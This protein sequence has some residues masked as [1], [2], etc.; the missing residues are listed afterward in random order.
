M[1]I[2]FVQSSNEINKVKELLGF[3]PIF[4]PLSLESLIYCDLKKIDY[5][6]PEILI[7]KNF[8]KIASNACSDLIKNLNLNK[9][10]FEFIRNEIKSIIR[11]KFNQIA[12]LIE[13]IDSLN[14]QKKITEIILTNQYS[15][16][17]YDVITKFPGN[18]FTNIEIIFLEIFKNYKIR[19]LDI[20]EK[21]IKNDLDLNHEYKITGLRY[22]N[23]KKIFFNNS[24]YNF[25]R[26]IIFLLKKRYKI[27]F[28]NEGIPFY[29]RFIFKIFGIEIIEFQKIRNI[30][31]K[32]K[33]NSNIKFTF[34]N[35]DISR[36]LNN[37]LIKS[38]NYLFDL[39]NKFKALS[40]FFDSSKIKLVIS[41]ANRGSGG[42]IVEK[43]VSKKIKSIMISHGTIAKSFDSDD[44]VYKKIIAEGVFS[45]KADYH[46][47]QSRITLDSLDTHKLTGK[48]LTTGN[49]VFAEGKQKSNLGKK[50]NCLYAVTNK[51]F[52]AMQFLGLEMYYEFFNNLN[53]LDNF[54]KENNYNFH[55]HL[56]YGAKDCINLL[57]ERFKNLNFTSGKIEKS[58]KNATVTISYSST[59]IEDSLHFRVPVILFD[60][61]L[62]YRHCESELDP[63]KKNRSIYYI[64]KNNDLRECL[65]T[66]RLSK[67]INFEEHIFLDY[68]KENIK[69]LFSNLI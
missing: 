61:R 62:R 38:S 3:K 60:P 12:L 9:F 5:L 39:E 19:V 45:G 65:E 68:S 43:A 44:E 2:C 46:A 40:N 11:F 1:K 27:S 28:F 26:L 23:K 30:K 6:N 64:N 57:K 22:K 13:I 14:K 7:E 58:L 69:R 24:G 17:E 63:R 49:L 34:K 67:N 21:K 55:I 54:S 59:V 16:Y 10:K 50:F 48:P 56:H 31:L 66:I 18:T 25:R 35:F 37:Q 51:P 32:E 33:Y 36:V 15:S 52:S 20:T 47:V 53:N 42:M 4:I 41:N 8:Y 29:K